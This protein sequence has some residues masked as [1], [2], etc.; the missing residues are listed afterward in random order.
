MKVLRV[1]PYKPPFEKD[2]DSGLE[3]LQHELKGTVQ[4][5]YPFSDPVAVL[6]NV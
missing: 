6:C 1:E 4:A 2:I 3:S 5:V